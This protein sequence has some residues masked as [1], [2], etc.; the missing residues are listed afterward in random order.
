[1]IDLLNNRGYTTFLVSN[2]TRPRV[3]E[4]CRPYQM[5][6]SLDAPDRETYNALCRPRGDYWDALQESLSLLSGRR[7]AVRITLVRG[8]NDRLP[9]EYAA[10]IGESNPTFVEVKAYMYLGYSRKRM[11]RENM[12]EHQHVRAF[13]DAIAEHSEYSVTDESP[14]SRVVLMERRE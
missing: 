3:L 9:E 2:G 5:Y 6:V 7:S 12:P 8:W 4:R 1:L 13:A 11:E 14:L 10:M